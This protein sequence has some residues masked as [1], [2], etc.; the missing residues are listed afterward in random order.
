MIT[1]LENANVVDVENGIILA[2]QYLVLE[3]GFIRELSEAKPSH[4]DAK[5]IDL[6][7]SYVIPGLIDAHVH[8]TAY[9]ANLGELPRQSPMYVAARAAKV[10]DGMLSR[11]FTT[12]RDVG[13]AEFG[14]AQSVEERLISGPR[15]L[16]GGKALSASGGHGDHRS[17]GVDRSDETYAQ[18][19]LGRRC[20]GVDE[21]RRAARDE[22]RRGAHHIKIMANGGI[23]SPTD[24]ITSDQFSE[25]EIA[26]IVDEANMANLYV[27]SHTY[28]ARSVARAVRNGVRSIEHGNLLDEETVALMKG[29]GSYLTPTLSCFRALAEVGAESGFPKDR[30]DKIKL[31]LDSGL[32]AVELAYRAGVPMA[33]GTDLIG[34]MHSRQLHEFELRADV[35]PPLD[36]LRAATS[37][38]AELVRLEHEIGHVK[39]NYRADLNILSANPLDKGVLESF[40]DHL[41]LVIQG[42]AVVKSYLL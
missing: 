38:A 24:R 9:T 33:Y 12:V 17:M 16:Y 30:M 8:V 40:V 25:E 26:A 20:D 28:T 18:V 1:I 13:G 36:L 3:N 34:P 22:I 35:V 5:R 39:Q 19:S 41:Q 15:L 27:V 11:G 31:V 2:D 4:S 23:S 32:H 7:G 37:T 42:G 21:V 14:L 29:A 6:K 10:L